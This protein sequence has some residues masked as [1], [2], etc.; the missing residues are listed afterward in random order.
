MLEYSEYV[1][2]FIGL[3]AVVS[4]FGAI[5]IFLSLTYGA[6][7]SEQIHLTN[8][9]AVSIPIILL[10]SL[11]FGELILNFFGITIASFKTGG[12]IL[13]LLMA[14][15][16]MHARPVVLHKLTKNYMKVNQK[17]P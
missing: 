14:I 15:E 10:M 3:F 4:P 11:F 16:M 2:M 17:N 13:I 12:G 5:P 8:V 9:I 7:K 6:E 1:K